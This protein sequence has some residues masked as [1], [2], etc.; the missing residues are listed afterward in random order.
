MRSWKRRKWERNGKG[1]LCGV[2]A[3]FIEDASVAAVRAA[4]I[5]SREEAVRQWF[6]NELITKLRYQK[7]NI[8]IE[9]PIQCFLERGYADVVVFHNDNGRKVPFILAEIKQP[10][11]NMDRAMKQLNAYAAGC[12]ETEY[13]VI[14]DGQNI[15]MANIHN[16]KYTPVKNLPVYKEHECNLYERY[17]YI[18]W[19]NEKHFCYVWGKSG[20]LEKV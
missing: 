7:T 8:D 15:S 6:I 9:Y 12:P 5:H 18:N 16:K 10:G 13:I 3:A 4:Y 11:E 14:T 19:K 1:N 2:N 17:E 20:Y